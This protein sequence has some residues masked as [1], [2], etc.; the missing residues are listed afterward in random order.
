MGKKAADGF[1]LI[2]CLRA[3]NVDLVILL[4]VPK[5]TEKS[6]ISAIYAEE[7]HAVRALNQSD[8][9]VYAV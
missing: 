4:V 6:V 5:I 8:P 1:K 2:H 9:K 3:G 7:A